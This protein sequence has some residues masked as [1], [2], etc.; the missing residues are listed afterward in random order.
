MQYSYN[1]ANTT[2]S[3]F[4]AGA[5]QYPQAGESMGYPYGTTP[6][7]WNGTA[8]AYTTQNSGGY[9]G[10]QGMALGANFSRM[11]ISTTPSHVPKKDGNNQIRTPYGTSLA[12]PS[13]HQTEPRNFAPRIGA[14]PVFLPPPPTFNLGGGSATYKPYT[15]S[16]TTAS[17]SDPFSTT[18][19]P[20]RAIAPTNS[21]ALTLPMVPED[22]QLSLIRHQLAYGPVPME[23]RAIRSD[24]LNKLTEGMVGLPTLDVALNADNFPFIE[25][26]SQAEAVSHGVIKIGNVSLSIFPMLL[27]P[28]TLR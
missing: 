14:A 22:G 10:A 6:T 9:A 18:S 24:Q 13:Y 16:Q 3:A 19:S 8:G 7:G 28:H 25:S 4:T 5:L 11:S 1:Q 21:Q 27:V 23:I 20:E 17:D 15:S 2:A 12:N 26:C